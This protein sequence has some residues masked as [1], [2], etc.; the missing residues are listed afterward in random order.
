MSGVVERFG[1]IGGSRLLD[2]LLA[3]A[4]DDRRIRLAVLREAPEGV[5]EM[6]RRRRALALLERMLSGPLPECVDCAS[7]LNRLA[8]RHHVASRAIGV[9]MTRIEPVLLD[10]AMARGLAVAV[11]ELLDH[12]DL[13]ASGSALP[14]QLAIGVSDDLLIVGLGAERGVA[15][16]ATLSAHRA[17]LRARAITQALGG[18][19][20]RG[21]DGDRIVLGL[22]FSR[23]DEEG[24]P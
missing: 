21:V 11:S 24:S 13:A 5:A 23:M 19:F 22:T 3:A 8:L 9:M 7:Y 6:P 4:R 18:D 20:E 16:L 2:R 15:P 10:A 14:I 1:R 17:L 12:V